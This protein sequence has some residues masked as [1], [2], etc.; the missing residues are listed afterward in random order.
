MLKALKE[1]QMKK[2]IL[3]ALWIVFIAV[4]YYIIPQ[5]E[6]GNTWELKWSK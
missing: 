4:F 5:T 2:I 6:K 3:A 1:K